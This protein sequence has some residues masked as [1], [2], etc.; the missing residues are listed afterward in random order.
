MSRT[1]GDANVLEAA[2]E[3]VSMIFDNFKRVCV[4]ISGGKDSTVVLHLCLQEA[5]RRGRELSAFFLDQEAEY[6]ASIT[7]VREQMKLP[8][9]IPEWYQVPMYLTNATSYT[10]YFLYA[11]GVGE[12]WMRDKETDSIHFAEGA[13][14]RFYDFFP[15]HESRH[16][17]TAFIVGIRAEES[18]T[19]Y[20]AVTKYAGWNGLKWSTKSG[21][22][23]R[24]YPIY[25]WGVSD[26]WKFIYEFNL[27]YNRM[28]DLMWLDGYS[29]YNRMRVSNLIH[30]KSFKCLVDLPRFEPETYDALCRRISG[31]HTASRYASEKLVFSNKQLPS[32]Y[33]TWREFR[34][35]LLSSIPED[36]HR[37]RFRKRFAGEKETESVFQAQVGQLLIND[38]E[39]SRSYDR[40][41][42]EKVAY[43]IEKWREI[44]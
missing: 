40:K 32:H 11:W 27:P 18:L 24:F 2:R 17:D 39:N 1:Y 20:R 8:G 43:L 6:A 16:P 25:D 15:W 26:V 14:E 28:Y 42:D 5:V 36:E 12:K 35:F 23:A 22:A 41:K 21:D 4:S 37:E 33:K 30:E 34:D 31:I 10:D 9:V 13:P 44:L 7:L 38:Y 29:I 19:R 3:R